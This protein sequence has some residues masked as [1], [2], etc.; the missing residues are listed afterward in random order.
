MCVNIDIV[1]DA[2]QVFERVYLPFSH[3]AGE[4]REDLLLNGMVYNNLPFKLW[5]RTVKGDNPAY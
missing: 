2:T 3:H 4:L 1:R 5:V